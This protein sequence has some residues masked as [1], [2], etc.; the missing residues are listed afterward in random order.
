MRGRTCVHYHPRTLPTDGRCFICGSTEHTSRECERPKVPTES[1]KPTYGKPAK[2]PGK[3]FGKNPGK[4]PGK[5]RV[6]TRKPTQNTRNASVSQAVVEDKP[7][8][9]IMNT[10]A[11]VMA[12][13]DQKPASKAVQVVSKNAGPHLCHF[14]THDVS[15]G[16]VHVSRSGSGGLPPGG[17]ERKATGTDKLLILLDGGATHDVMISASG[18]PDGATE[19]SVSMAQGT[20][21]GYV[22]GGEV[23]LVEPEATVEEQKYPRLMSLGRLISECNLVLT[24]GPDGAFLRLPGGEKMKLVVKNYCP[25]GTAED[26]RKLQEIRDANPILKYVSRRDVLLEAL[27]QK[28]SQLQAWRTKIKTMAD[29]ARHHQN[30]HLPFS[31][32]CPECRQSVGA[33]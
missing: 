14:G 29:L 31:P 8:Q 2:G 17:P 24:W 7:Q 12:V 10:V 26:L 28:R 27:Q 21:S 22:L 1:G 15:S 32:E 16:A 9:D 19:E 30:G 23:T 11:A 20:T 25:Y 18:V 4:G 5:N 6:D 3:G 33:S 13:L